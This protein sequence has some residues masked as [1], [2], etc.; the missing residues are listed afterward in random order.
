MPLIISETD[1]RVCYKSLSLKDSE[2]RRIVLFALSQEKRN[3][4]ISIDG[5]NITVEEKLL[6]GVN[7]LFYADFS[8]FD[9]S[10]ENV[11]SEAKNETP[12]SLASLTKIFADVF[13]Q[14]LKEKGINISVRHLAKDCTL[15]MPLGA[16]ITCLSLMVR[17]F[18]TSGATVTLEAV[19]RD[20]SVAFYADGSLGRGADSEIAL[21]MLHEVAYSNGF[22]VELFESGERTSLKIELSPTDI[23]DYGFKADDLIFTE[24][25]CEVSLDLL[26]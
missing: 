5:R 9:K 21:D 15:K 16:V 1:G 4:I 22:S 11:L 24:R 3:G 6:G 20:K 19:R 25:L 14:P 17:F 12:V 8:R 26:F 23:S 18:F 10:A 7:R 13:M 2:A